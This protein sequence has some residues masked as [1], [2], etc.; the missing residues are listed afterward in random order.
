[1]PGPHFSKSEAVLHELCPFTVAPLIFYFCCSSSRFIPAPSCSHLVPSLWSCPPPGPQW[2]RP[3]PPPPLS[4]P[5]PSRT[6]LPPPLP[7]VLSA[8]SFLLSCLQ[9]AI[10]SRPES[11]GHAG[12]DFT[13]SSDLAEIGQLTPRLL[14]RTP[15]G[16]VSLRQRAAHVQRGRSMFSRRLLQPT[17]D[18]DEANGSVETRI[19]RRDCNYAL[20]LFFRFNL[21]PPLRA[22]NREE[23]KKKKRK[24]RYPRFS[25]G[26]ELRSNSFADSMGTKT[27][28]II[29][30]K[31]RCGPWV[32]HWHGPGNIRELQKAYVTRAVSFFPREASFLRTGA[33]SKRTVEGPTEA[34]GF[35]SI[36]NT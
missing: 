4:T 21:P 28:E 6:T 33:R 30:R 35:S 23:E 9:P 5:V 12:R 20:N 25:V 27:I 36:R 11:P 13:S 3:L 1:M 14:P 29:L 26:R 19:P 32:R 8:L 34:E 10:V 31:P 15:P 2:P 18:S 17:R 22:K 7:P 24:G 16:A